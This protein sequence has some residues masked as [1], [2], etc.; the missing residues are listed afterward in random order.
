MCLQP[1]SRLL[2]SRVD[3]YAHSSITEVVCRDSKAKGVWPFALLL[4]LRLNT[5]RSCAHACASLDFKS[6]SELSTTFPPTSGLLVCVR[7][8]VSRYPRAHV[9]Q[10]Q[11]MYMSPP[12]SIRWERHIHTTY[13]QRRQVLRVPRLV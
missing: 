6:P 10:H 2:H 11:P 13:P 8:N 12:T 4:P 1:K 3:G 5:T 7:A 9:L